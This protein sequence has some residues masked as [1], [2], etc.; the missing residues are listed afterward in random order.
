MITG[1]SIVLDDYI[2]PVGPFQVLLLLAFL[3]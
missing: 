2:M 3:F 1:Y